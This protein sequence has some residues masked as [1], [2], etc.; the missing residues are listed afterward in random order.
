MIGASRS[1]LTLSIA[2]AGVGRFAASVLLLLLVVAVVVLLRRAIR[3]F[4]IDAVAAGLA[5]GF[6][7]I[8]ST[9]HSCVVC[10]AVAVYRTKDIVH[11]PIV[12]AIS[13][14]KYDAITVIVR[15]RS[16]RYCTCSTCDTV[17]HRSIQYCC[18][19]NAAALSIASTG[20]EDVG[21]AGVLL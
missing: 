20:Q 17:R 2:D 14:L 16:I 10:R 19:A 18:Q 11:D 9:L 5:C 12:A 4:C 15:R 6:Y 21:R 3:C 8:T 13:D 7:R 1:G